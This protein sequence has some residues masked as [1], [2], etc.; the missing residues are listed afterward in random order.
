MPMTD[1]EVNHLRRLLAWLECEYSL[2]EHAALGC[3]KAATA[4]VAHGFTTPEQGSALL[5]EKA[6]QINQVP[7]YV[8]QA[9]KMLTKAL[10]E[11]ERK[12]GIVGD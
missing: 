7:A 12:S 10:R 3:L 4:M 8:R 5:H 11:H 9:H 1:A 2:G 6:K